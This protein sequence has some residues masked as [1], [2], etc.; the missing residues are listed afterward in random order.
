M[1]GNTNN[2]GNISIIYVHTLAYV[3]LFSPVKSFP[4][5]LSKFKV[6]KS[7]DVELGPKYKAPGIVTKNVNI[8]NIIFANTKYLFIFFYFSFLHG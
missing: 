4:V 2:G 7:V 1:A 8:L 3:A 6:I 5:H